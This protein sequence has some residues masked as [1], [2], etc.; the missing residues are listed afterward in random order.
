MPT[1][2]NVITLP[3]LP[4][5]VHTVG[6]VV[7]NDTTKPLDAVADTVTGDCGNVLAGMDAKIG[8]DADGLGKLVH[9]G[10]LG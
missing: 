6:V 8:M 9:G 3:L 4:P 2:R 1:A 5:A 7:V 10:P